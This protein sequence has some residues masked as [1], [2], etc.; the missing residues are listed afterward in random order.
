MLRRTFSSAPRLAP[1][2]RQQEGP[3]T[4]SQDPDHLQAPAQKQQCPLQ[5]RD[6]PNAAAAVLSRD[7]SFGAANSQS[8]R[9]ASKLSQR[10]AGSPGA[11]VGDTWFSLRLACS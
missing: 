7:D 2:I 3:A 10:Q 4:A 9:L 11:P 8:G 6:D 5:R 1:E